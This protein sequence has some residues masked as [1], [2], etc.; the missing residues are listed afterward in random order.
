[1]LHEYAVEPGLLKNWSDFRFFVGQFGIEHGRLISRFPKKWKRLVYESLG[2]CPAV[3]KARIEEGLRRI[4]RRLLV[5]THD[6]NHLLTWRRNAEQEHGKR[7]F[8]ALLAASNPNSH[9]AVIV[10]A[11]VDDTIDYTGLAATDSRLLWKAQRSRIVQ[12]DA[13]SMAQ[14]VDLLL[15]QCGKVL[16]VDKH[17]GPENVR[18]RLPLESFLLTIARR[19]TAAASVTVE[20]H[21]GDKSTSAFFQ[22]EC[23]RQLPA[24]VPTGMNVRLVRWASDDLH[25]RFVLTDCGGVAFLEGLDQYAGSGRQE[26]VVAVLDHDVC[27]ALVSCYDTTCGKFTF[28]DECTVVGTKV[29]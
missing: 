13:A 14:A 17:F 1:M 25:N 8:R 22:A 23:M 9:P 26:D 2:Q 10:G 29:I 20:V 3:E 18:H 5:R 6:W 4:D 21:T 7:P 27:V 24:V 12:R 11:D 15:Q 19:N 28:V 16:F